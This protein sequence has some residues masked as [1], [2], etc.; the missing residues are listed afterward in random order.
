MPWIRRSRPL[1][2][3][4]PFSHPLGGISRGGVSDTPPLPAPAPAP[5]HPSRSPES[6][7]RNPIRGLFVSNHPT[8]LIRCLHTNLQ[9][10]ALL[11]PFQLQRG[12]FPPPNLTRGG[13]DDFQIGGGRA[14]ERVSGIVYWVATPLGRVAQ[15][16]GVA[17]LPY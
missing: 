1:T 17:T 16:M 14:S 4:P 2:P 6:H 3:A 11:D 12:A 13:I 10:N 9:P 5:I 8:P 7:P 15:G